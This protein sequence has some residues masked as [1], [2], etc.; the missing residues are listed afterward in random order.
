VGDERANLDLLRR[1]ILNV[2]GHEL[3]T[4][5]TTLRGLAELLG[6]TEGD[7]EAT[8]ALHDAIKRAAR[9]SEALVDDLLVAAGIGTAL[10]VAPLAPT[11]VLDAAAKAW[12]GID[13]PE[14]VDLAVDVAPGL[15]VL[16]RPG[17]LRRALEAVLDNAVRHGGEPI[18]LRAAVDGDEVEIV[19]TDGGPG[20]PEAERPLATEAFFRGERA[21]TTAPGL[22]LGLSLAATLVG[23]DG[24]AIEVSEA[25]GGGTAVVL[26]LPIGAA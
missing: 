13:V 9:R 19:V 20:I 14:G 17:S 12:A 25:E 21:V 3:R 23:Q 26:H 22:G 16:A 8:R 15:V 2:V 1:R 5:V 18:E 6:T 11:D 4:P 7:P 10:P 24:G